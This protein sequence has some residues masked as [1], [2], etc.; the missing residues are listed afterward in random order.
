VLR[1]RCRAQGASAVLRILENE[2]SIDTM[3]VA[4]SKRAILARLLCLMGDTRGGDEGEAGAGP[5]GRV[6]AFVADDYHKRH[7]LIQSVLYELYLKT[8][9]GGGE[10]GVREEGAGPA[11][12]PKDFT[13]YDN[14]LLALIRKLL[15][16]LDGR[17]R[18]LTATYQV[19]PRLTEKVLDIMVECVEDKSGQR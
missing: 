14:L 12:D 5:W 2:A 8:I 1:E 11:A 19:A 4:T 10:P 3:D 17:D 6:V 7:L 16:K 18:M 15:T 9:V 13:L